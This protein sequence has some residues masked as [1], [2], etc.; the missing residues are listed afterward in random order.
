MEFR[1]N[2][3][4]S[5]FTQSSFLGAALSCSKTIFK[6]NYSHASRMRSYSL[7]LQWANGTGSDLSAMYNAYKVWCHQHTIDDF[8]TTDTKMNRDQMHRSEAEWADKYC[9]DLAAMYEC[10]EQIDEMRMRL[11]C[12]GIGEE[13]DVSRVHWNAKDM[14]II[15]KTII[16]GAFYP[17][18]FV[19]NI[20]SN[21][22]P[23]N[24]FRELDGHDPRNTI[25]FKGFP[26][27][28]IRCLYT[29]AIKNIFVENGCVD[30]VHVDGMQVL[31]DD[32]TEKVYVTF[33]STITDVNRGKY[34]VE[35]MPGNTEI[36]VYKAVKMRK[37]RM[38][39]NLR[40]MK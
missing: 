37:F 7:L 14:P 22:N 2:S 39:N 20:P 11:K 33:K 31:F 17:N 40:V 24:A 21:E 5:D 35:R 32:E 16:S 23:R 8:G 18:I 25:Y 36:E 4:N 6:S 30:A 38:Q 26:R 29:K 19:T 27:N 28:N 1:Q 12:L 15:L 13:D 9:I 10:K 34:G 3:L